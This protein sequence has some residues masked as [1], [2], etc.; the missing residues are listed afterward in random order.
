MGKITVRNIQ[1]LINNDV[2]GHLENE[3]F[4]YNFSL[5]YFFFTFHPTLLRISESFSLGTHLLFTGGED[6]EVP[7]SPSTRSGGDD[8]FP[9]FEVTMGEIVKV[10]VWDYVLTG[11]S[12]L[13]T[14]W[15]VGKC[16]LTWNWQLL[17]LNATFLGCPNVCDL[18]IRVTLLF[19][20]TITRGSLASDWGQDTP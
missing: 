4:L 6:S 9:Y 14:I 1:V 12:I 13:N 8:F 17:S 7:P 19:V 15:L 16:H 10:W 5:F 3:C 18:L 20:S 11:H 2:L